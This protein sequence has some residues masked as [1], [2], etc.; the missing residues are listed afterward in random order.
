MHGFHSKDLLLTRASITQAAER[1]L[2]QSAGVNMNTWI[3]GHTPIGHHIRKPRDGE[4][5][6]VE[7]TFFLRGRI[8]AGQANLEGNAYGLNDFKWLTKQEMAKVLKPKYFSQVR[9]MLSDR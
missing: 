2:V 5:R 3:V 7:K 9:N 6:A 4:N 8:M 1:I